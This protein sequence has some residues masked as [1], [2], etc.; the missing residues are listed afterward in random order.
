MFCVGKNEK[1]MDVVD[2]IQVTRKVKYIW[3]KMV[4]IS[5]RRIGTKVKTEDEVF[6]T[7]H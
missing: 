6:V 5:S 4:E 7:F 2:Q 3:G 1:L